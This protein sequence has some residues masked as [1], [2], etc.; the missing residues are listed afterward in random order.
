[1]CI[2]DSF[3][4]AYSLAVRFAIARNTRQLLLSGGEDGSNKMPK[5]TDIPP[6]MKLQ[7]Y[8]LRH[9]LEHEA[10]SKVIVGFSKPEHVLETVEFVR[11]ALGEKAAGS[12]LS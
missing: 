5:Y 9:A 2:R 4:A 1:M 10:V 3:F 6:D 8:A 12:S 7:E 11:K